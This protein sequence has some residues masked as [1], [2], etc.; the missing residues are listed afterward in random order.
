MDVSNV[1]GFVELVISPSVRIGVQS[2]LAVSNHISPIIL[3]NRGREGRGGVGGKEE[4]GWEGRKRRGGREGRGGVGGKEE[5]GWE[6]RKRR[7]GEEKG[8]RE[9]G[10]GVETK[11]FTYV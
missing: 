8:R 1:K 3:W 7:E 11:L 5:E 2:L 6:G 10:R 4:E 9:E